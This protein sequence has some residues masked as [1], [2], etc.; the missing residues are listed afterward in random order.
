M[1]YLNIFKF[2]FPWK[3]KILALNMFL[4][5]FTFIHNMYVFCYNFL[6][7]LTKT[8]LVFWKNAILLDGV[9]LWSLFLRLFISV[10]SEFWEHYVTMCWWALFSA[11]A[12]CNPEEGPLQNHGR[13]GT[14]ILDLQPPQLWETHFCCLK[15]K[16]KK[17]KDMLPSISSKVCC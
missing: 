13:A 6:C 9:L 5:S 10:L 4:F 12:I 2:I 1:D 14:L 7:M 3:F 11:R 16:K 17:K 8:I 15:A